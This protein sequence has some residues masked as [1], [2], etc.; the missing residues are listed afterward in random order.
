MSI[1]IYKSEKEAGLEKAIA[2]STNIVYA[3]LATP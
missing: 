1:N 3:S 2:A